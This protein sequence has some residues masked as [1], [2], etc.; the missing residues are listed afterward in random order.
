[1]NVW[2]NGTLGSSGEAMRSA[3]DRAA[4][5]RLLT[6]LREAGHDCTCATAADHPGGPGIC[7]VQCHEKPR[8]VRIGPIGA[9]MS[10]RI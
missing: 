6:V 3:G 7:R 4:L 10:C 8:A 9:K 1:M 5:K 2:S